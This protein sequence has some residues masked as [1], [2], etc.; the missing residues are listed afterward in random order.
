MIVSL[1]AYRRPE[2][3][4]ETIAA[5]DIAADALAE[6]VGEPTLLFAHIEPGC[7]EIEELLKGR[8]RGTWVF[9][10]N[11]QKGCSGNTL[12]ALDHAFFIAHRF[13][14]DY[15]QHLE[16]DFVL[17][18]D[19]LLLSAWIRDTYRLDEDVLCGGVQTAHAAT[20]DEYLAVHK[21]GWFHCQAWSTWTDRWGSPLRWTWPFD[22]GGVDLGGWAQRFN[23]QVFDG[24][25]FQVIPRLS[26]CKHIGLEGGLHTTP[27]TFEKDYP[28]VYAGDVEI[29][30]GAYHEVP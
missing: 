1:T 13:E 28:R 8:G 15:V 29:P 27:T 2:Y 24:S 21:N 14:E 11:E 19:A 23:D 16:E 17:A 3:L 10:N 26:R 5:L 7:P 9:V 18:P 12:Q 22:V 6:G 20:P 30:Q 25:R 4:A